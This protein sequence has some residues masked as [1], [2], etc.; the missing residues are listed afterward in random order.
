MAKLVLK[1]ESA[2]IREVPLGK[3]T[4][5][6]GR[7]PDNDLQIDNLTVSEHHARILAEANRLKIEDLDSLNGISVNGTARKMEW[8]S[9][10]DNVL[11][12]K[13]VIVV[14]LEHDV[15]M[16]DQ[17]R[18]SAATP[19][20]EE[21]YA[22]NYPSRPDLAHRSG[23]EETAADAFLDRARIPS[24][25]V[26]KGQTA[27]KEY[28]LSNKLT[29]IGRSSM[30][31]VRLTGWFKPQ[32]AAQISKRQDSYYVNPISSRAILVNGIRIT[33]ATRLNDGD[34]IEVAGVSLKFTYGE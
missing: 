19:R 23:T 13:H 28:V 1:F 15:A 34:M 4:I 18:P 26:V 24:V 7:A 17:T 30:A 21:T 27:Q 6:I 8:L 25:I 29:L 16:F 9:S 2:V 33:N 10:G 14:D 12:G 22:L 20:L 31:T 5:T 11:I 3:R 32:A